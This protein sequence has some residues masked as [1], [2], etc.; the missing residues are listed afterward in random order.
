MLGAIALALAFNQIRPVMLLQPIQDAVFWIEDHYDQWYQAHVPASRLTILVFAFLGGLVAS[1]SPCILALLPVNLSYIGTRTITSRRD[2]LGKAIAFVLGVVT[3]LSILG[4]VSSAASFVLLQMQGYVYL[5][6]GTLIV[7]MGLNLLGWVPLPLPKPQARLPIP[8]AYGVGLTFAL[9]TSPCTS[10]FLFSI[11]GVAATT[12]SQLQSVL[13][14]VSY[15][16]GYTAVLFAA[17]VL[18]GFAKQ[19]RSLLPHSQR[20]VLVGAM[21]LIV[22]GLYYCISGL[23]WIVAMHDLT[24]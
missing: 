18:T 19:A 11:L 9:V 4:L 13:T 24:F 21:V 10:P 7:G 12:G 16:L 6:V 23:R 5:A 20:I 14:M 2:A 17:S 22:A 8:G 3:V 15:A 1:I